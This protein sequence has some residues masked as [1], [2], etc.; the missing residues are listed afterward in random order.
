MKRKGFTLI[1]LLVVIAIIA[2]LAAILFPVFARAKEKANQTKCMSNSRQIAFALQFYVKDHDGNFPYTQYGDWGY[3]AAMLQV[4][5]KNWQVFRCPGALSD[6]IPITTT[7]VP[8]LTYGWNE[9]MMWDYR[10]YIKIDKIPNPSATALVAD[11][12]INGIFQ[13]WDDGSTESLKPKGEKLPQGFCRLK[14]ANWPLDSTGKKFLRMEVRHGG[15]SIVY[16][17]THV[18]FLTPE[19]FY[20]SG[21]WGDPNSVQR[22]LIFPGARPL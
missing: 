3:W 13:D 14:Y 2:I 20:F 6:R 1:E 22:P 15:T 9:Y 7:K 10:E 21:K 12:A 8:I 18:G 17:D 11:C 4:Y 19:K 5:I 16:A